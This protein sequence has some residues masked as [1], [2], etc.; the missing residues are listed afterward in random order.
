VDGLWADKLAIGE[1]LVRY[2]TGIDRRDWPRFRTC[3][4][5]DVETDYA[6]LRIDGVDAL[7]DYMTA[8]HRDMGETRH[9]LSNFAIDV[10]GDTATARSY[11]HAVL[12]VRPGDPEA[13]IDVIGSYDDDLVRAAEG[14]RIRRRAFTLVRMLTPGLTPDWT[15]PLNDAS[16]A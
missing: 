4:T 11:V 3:W 12:M 15:A 7:T 2:A 5:D 1:V 16:P 9:Q 10:D 8:A 14:W 13:Y 6:G